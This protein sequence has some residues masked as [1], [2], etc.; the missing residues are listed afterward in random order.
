M[1]S[2]RR[3]DSG[4]RNLRDWRECI[5][6]WSTCQHVSASKH[7]AGLAGEYDRVFGAKY[8]SSCGEKSW[9]ME[10]PGGPSQQLRRL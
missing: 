3:G 2:A 7:Q 8:W 10:R 6:C 5:M 1:P 9:L 4:A